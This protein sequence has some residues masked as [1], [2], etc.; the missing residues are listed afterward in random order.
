MK[1]KNKIP[2]IEFIKVKSITNKHGDPVA[3][4]FIIWTPEGRYLQSFGS[5]IAFVPI[6]TFIDKVL[7]K[8]SCWDNQFHYEIH[9][10]DQFLGEGKLETERKIQE[11]IYLLINK[12]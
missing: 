11:G 3:D 10:L 12:I 2:F 1:K 5:L 8:T 6:S 7:I 9:A 4:Q